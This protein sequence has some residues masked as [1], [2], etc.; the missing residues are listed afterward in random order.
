VEMLV[1]VEMQDTKTGEVLFAAILDRGHRKGH[2]VKEED[3]SWEVP[4]A[5]AEKLGRRL[6]CQLDN[7]RLSAGKKT[8]CLKAIPIGG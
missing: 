8:D 4:G 1:E 5:I 2:H 6:A 3:V 7:G